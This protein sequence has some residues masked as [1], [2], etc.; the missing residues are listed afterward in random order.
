MSTNPCAPPPRAAAPFARLLDTVRIPWAL[1]LL[2]LIPL[3]AC[4]RSA[5]QRRAGEEAIERAVRAYLVR[6]SEAYLA[7]DAGRLEGVA[8]LREMGGLERRLEELGVEGRRL[9]PTLVEAVVEEI[10]RYD[11]TNATVRMLE[12]WDLRV[13]DR[14][15][16]TVLSESLGQSN[17]VAYHLVRERGEWLVLFRQ[18]QQTVE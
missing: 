4:A 7:E 10:N 1:L 18:L 14:G 5:E 15:S 3:G 12:R 16:G 11:A 13:V 2:L 9:E 17:R 6:M 8:T